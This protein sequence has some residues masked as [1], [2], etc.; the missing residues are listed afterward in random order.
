[1]AFGTIRPI[2]LSPLSSMLLSGDLPL[3]SLG[4]VRVLDAR[5]STRGIPRLSRSR[6]G[7]LL[8]LWVQGS[9]GTASERIT[10]VS[11]DSTRSQLFCNGT[12]L[13]APGASVGQQLWLEEP[14]F[15]DSLEVN[16]LGG[17]VCESA[18][19]LLHKSEGL[20]VYARVRTLLGKSDR[21]GSQGGLRKRGC[22]ARRSSIPTHQQYPTQMCGKVTTRTEPA[23]TVPT[24]TRLAPEP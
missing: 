22:C 23:D 21:S 17:G 9:R 3:V 1:M 16:E 4:P 2:A 8:A 19:K 6:A 18:L 14:T 10:T 15:L 5:L 20:Q 24:V 7:P 11:L 12:G 13:W